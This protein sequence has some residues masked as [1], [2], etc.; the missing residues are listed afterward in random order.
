MKSV[1]I[2]TALLLILCMNLLAQDYGDLNLV[3]HYT[4]LE[5][6]EDDTGI[7]DT[8]ELINA[9]YQGSN[10]VYCYGAYVFNAQ[11]EDS[12]LVQTPKLDALLDTAFAFQLEFRLDTIRPSTPI[13]VAGNSWRYLGLF[14]NSDTTIRAL[15]NGSYFNTT[16]DP[17]NLD[18]WYTVAV[19]H[20][21]SG[22]GNS[23]FYL[24][25]QLIFE[26]EGQLDHAANDLN[27]SNSHFGQGRA[28]RGNWRNLMVYAATEVSGVS[29][30]QEEAIEVF[31]NPFC[32]DLTIKSEKLYGASYTICDQNGRAVDAGMVGGQNHSLS[33]LPTGIY[34]LRIMA[35]TG[36]IYMQ[37]IEKL[38]P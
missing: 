28:F 29:P 14:I 32:G 31:P 36:K 2:L 7:Q 30:L 8:I 5:T 27:I 34:F 21:K 10:G 4:L 38:C 26:Q 18:Q 13:V 33:S 24:D 1:S 25:G 17:L 12:T 11:G 16:S 9:P 20:D 3:A 6:T 19:L 37:P 35:P 23:E 22:N 15:H